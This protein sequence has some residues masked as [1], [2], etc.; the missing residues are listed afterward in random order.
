[1]RLDASSVTTH[2]FPSR[3]VLFAA[4]FSV[5]AF[6]QP[7]PASCQSDGDPITVGTYRALHSDVLDEDRVLQIHLPEGHTSGRHALSRGLPVCR[8]R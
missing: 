8:E 1:M 6:L 4:A 3:A 5:A 7:A 2:P